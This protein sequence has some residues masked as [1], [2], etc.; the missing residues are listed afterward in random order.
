M[1]KWPRLL[2]HVIGL[3]ALCRESFRHQGSRTTMPDIS[4]IECRAQ[5][6]L[7]PD[8]SN[9]A[10]RRK[11]FYGPSRKV[12]MAHHVKKFAVLRLP[13]GRIDRKRKLSDPGTNCYDCDAVTCPCSENPPKMRA[14]KPNNGGVWSLPE[15]RCSAYTDLRNTLPA[16]YCGS[17]RYLLRGLPHRWT[18]INCCSN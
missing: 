8:G 6:S 4:G 11:Y 18:K 9:S 15:N 14:Q 17:S 1:L 3:S 12:S 13:I 16:G 5:W 2:N 10:A 7:E